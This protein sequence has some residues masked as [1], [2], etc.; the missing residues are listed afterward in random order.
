MVRSDVQ[1]GTVPE[2]MGHSPNSQL[3]LGTVTTR[4]ARR[5]S[6]AGPPRAAHPRGRRK[7]GIGRMLHAIPCTATEPKLPRPSL[8]ATRRLADTRVRHRA[9]TP[10]RLWVPL[11][12]RPPTLRAAMVILCDRRE[13]DHPPRSAAPAAEPVAGDAVTAPPSAPV[14]VPGSPCWIELATS[15]ADRSMRFYQAVLGWDYRWLHDDAGQ[16]YLLALLGDE[17]VAGFRPQPHA[18]RD[19]TPYLAT[20]DLPGTASLVQRLGGA[21]LDTRPHV[22]PG[23]GAKALADD[24]GGATVGLVQPAGDWAFTAGVSGALVWLEFV[25]RQ[26]HHADRFYASPVRLPATPVRRWPH[27]RLHGLHHRERRRRRL[28]Q[29]RR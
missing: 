19:W 9:R 20:P 11:G 12:R 26:P 13:I 24:P 14:A 22:V 21:M 23:V 8:A 29:Q 16:G 3:V 2:V 10:L 17:P 25:T 15:D 28:G 7:L 18:V 6:R 27:R 1:N 5:G 4:R